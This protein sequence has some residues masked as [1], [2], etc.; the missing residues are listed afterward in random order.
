MNLRKALDKAKRERD[1]HGGGKG[2]LSPGASPS[3]PAARPGSDWHAPVYSESKTAAIDLE[4]AV[5]NHCV[6]LS[7]DFAEVDYYK[8]LRTQLRQIGREKTWNTIMVTS[9]APGE[10]KTV[11][12]INLAATFAREYNQ[13]VLL[14]DADL[15][16]QSIHHYLG[17]P[18]S[19]GLR[20]YLEERVPMNDI[21]TWPG[22]E[23]FTV[24]S[25]GQPV[26][27]SA[28]LM[29]SPRMQTLVAELKNRY[30]DR[31]VIF[32]VPPV[33][34]GADALTFAPL[35]DCIILVVGVGITRR[36]DLTQALEMLPQEKMA[37][38]VLNQF[39]RAT[40]HRYGH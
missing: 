34:G 30:A 17:Y 12:A 5:S 1:S 36:Q 11:T 22:I 40:A 24:I 18:S 3:F 35:V 14:V 31:Y 27:E 7:A 39:N 20:D 9:V 2:P 8:V 4:T 16:R 6:A 23:K 37:G 26:H 10:G 29:G 19:S 33:M 13:T 15:R 21:I 28:E 32:D 38:F 25:G